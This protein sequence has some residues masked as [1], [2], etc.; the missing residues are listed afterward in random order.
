MQPVLIYLVAPAGAGPE[1]FNNPATPQ[2][3]SGNEDSKVRPAC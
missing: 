1:F 2:N 3:V